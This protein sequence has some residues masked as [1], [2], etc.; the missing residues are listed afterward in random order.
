MAQLEAQ[1]AAD[2]EGA[3]KEAMEHL[4]SE[5]ARP[6]AIGL[7]GYELEVEWLPFNASGFSRAKF[8]RPPGLDIR[9]LV[10]VNRTKK[11]GEH[12]LAVKLFSFGNHAG[13]TPVINGVPCPL[14][15]KA[16]CYE[17]ALTEDEFE[18]VLADM[19]H[20]GRWGAVRGLLLMGPLGC[21]KTHLAAAIV[22]AAL[23][24]PRIRPYSVIFDR[25]DRLIT[26]IQDTYGTG[27]TSAI[28]ELRER[29]HLLVIDDLGRE[30]ATPDTLRILIDLVNAREAHPTVITSNY[31]PHGLVQRWG[32]AEGW[33][34]LASRLGPQELPPCDR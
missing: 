1:W 33:Q 34:R 9:K 10:L 11:S 17:Y 24:S 6:S 20:A 14:A 21:G 3:E 7:D 25:A 23:L 27:K 15:R 18:D 8:A 28:L 32:E 19:L 13:E 26:V 16:R 30:K 12:R 5:R 31:T 29:A 2:P 22:R 4:R